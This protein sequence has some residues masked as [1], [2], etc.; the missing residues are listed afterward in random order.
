MEVTIGDNLSVKDLQNILHIHHGF[1][2]PAF[3]RLS[4]EDHVLNPDV[5]LSSVGIVDGSRLFIVDLPS[6]QS[7]GRIVHPDGEKVCISVLKF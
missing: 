2:A 5:A 4:F 3:Q 1:S 6:N 7:L